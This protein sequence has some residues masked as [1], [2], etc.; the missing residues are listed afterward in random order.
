MWIGSHRR[1]TAFPRGSSS[2]CLID[3]EG[4]SKLKKSYSEIY[5]D[6]ESSCRSY[7]GKS[8]SEIN[9][10]NWTQQVSDLSSLRESLCDNVTVDTSLFLIR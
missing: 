10:C 2:D 4:H 5:K 1:D 3:D 9:H 6:E 7:G 8:S